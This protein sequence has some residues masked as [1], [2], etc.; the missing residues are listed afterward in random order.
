MRGLISSDERKGA[1]GLHTAWRHV[2]RTVFAVGFLAVA[3][4][5]TAARAQT[6]PAKPVHL[7]SPSP[8]GGGTD[9]VSRLLAQKLGESAKWTVVVDTMPGAGNNIGLRFGAKATPDGYTLVMGETSNLAVNQFL[10][11]NLGFDPAKDLAPV[12]L[13]GSGPLVLV[14]RSASPYADLASVLAASRKQQLTFASSGNGTVGHLVAE[15]VRTSSG[16]DMLHVPYK[17]AGPAM[18]DLLGGQVDIYYASLT[19]ALPMIKSGKLRALAVTSG[20]RLS[21]LAAVPTLI[22]SGFP[23]FEYNVFYGVVAPAGTPQPVVEL[24]N[25][26]IN[27]ALDGSETRTN[28]SERGIF[29]QPGTPEDFARFLEAE[30]KKWGPIVKASGASAD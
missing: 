6:F 25:K 3:V 21:E 5:S 9:A 19:A 23:G 15:S 22:E 2:V 17:G 18:T 11:K 7:V 29:P 14:V 13:I 27:T 20:K 10:Y 28:L 1:A 24:L 12:A 30:R 16:G 26:Q 8:P 4:A